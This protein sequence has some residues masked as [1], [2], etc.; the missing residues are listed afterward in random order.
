[1][2]AFSSVPRSSVRRPPK[3]GA[4]TASP[5][6][7]NVLN[8]ARPEG[9][10]AKGPGAAGPALAPRAATRRPFMPKTA[11]P[12][13]SPAKRALS[14]CT[15]PLAKR[16][17]E[18]P[19]GS[20]VPVAR[21]S[22][23]QPLGEPF[24]SLHLTASPAADATL[25]ATS[26]A[27]VALARRLGWQ[28]SPPLRRSARRPFDTHDDEEL[29]GL[30]PPSPGPAPQPPRGVPLAVGRAKRSDVVNPLGRLLG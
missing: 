3:G 15:T 26:D 1:M 19:E 2:Q 28:D 16:C 23:S 12:A 27:C 21:W 17:P 10:G 22:P 29:A 14:P 24:A 7:E 11:A 8:A 4:A 30:Q 6:D 18:A 25:P 13:H 9:P 5:N 20:S